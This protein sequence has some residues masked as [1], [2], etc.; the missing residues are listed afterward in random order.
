MAH[1]PH[2][3]Q[4]AAGTITAPYPAEDFAELLTHDPERAFALLGAMTPAQCEA[5]AEA[6]VAW[7]GRF[8]LHASLALVREAW[9]IIAQKTLNTHSG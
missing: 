8:G 7:L 6:Y 5:Q 9:D 2:P 4:L 3:P 1:S